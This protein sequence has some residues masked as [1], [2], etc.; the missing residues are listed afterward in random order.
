MVTTS[1]INKAGKTLRSW[2]LSPGSGTDPGENEHRALGLLAEYRAAHAEPL[3]TANNGLRSMLRTEECAVNVSQRLKR[4]STILDKLLRQPNMALSTMQDIGRCRAIVAN[5]DELR[6]IAKR[7]AW[8]RP[9]VRVDDYASHPRPSGYRAVHIVVRYDERC[10]EIQLRT[11]LM[12]EWAVAVERLGAQLDEDLKS[13]SGPGELLLWLK[14][15]SEALAIEDRG[16]VVDSK[17]SDRISQLRVA[18]LPF[19][20]GG[21]S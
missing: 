12:H 15:I 18:A 17:L 3:I 20:P 4:T 1:Q 2:L 14:A 13:G 10:I 19:L 21:M 7:V 8:R 11:R 6:R 5:V 9:P 16:E